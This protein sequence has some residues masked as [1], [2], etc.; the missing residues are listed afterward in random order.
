MTKSIDK[1]STEK[2][3]VHKAAVID[4]LTENITAKT[5][6]ISDLLGIMD[7]RT[8]R[9]LSEMVD[10]GIIVAEGANRN[11]VYKLKT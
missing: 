4:Y 2:T 8:S 10:E 5:P 7:A 1:K 6:E 11:R 3:K 9:L